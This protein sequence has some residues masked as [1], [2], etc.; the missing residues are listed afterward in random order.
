L[1]DISFTCEQEESRVRERIK[2]GVVVLI[3]EDRKG[4]EY[5]MVHAPTIRSTTSFELIIAM[6]RPAPGCVEAPT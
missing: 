4:V 3:L 6:G 1:R 2:T 5:F